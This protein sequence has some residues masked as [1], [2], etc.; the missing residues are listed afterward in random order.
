VKDYISNIRHLAEIL[1]LLK[2]FENIVEDILSMFPQFPC[3]SSKCGH[4]LDTFFMHRTTV[5][6]SSIYFVSNNFAKVNN[7][8]F[9]PTIINISP[10]TLLADKIKK[11]LIINLS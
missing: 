5:D 3:C 1:N 11:K 7:H 8:S 10:L 4:E 6:C 2:D 9:K